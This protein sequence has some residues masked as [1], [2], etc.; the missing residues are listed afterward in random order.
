VIKCEAEKHGERQ[1]KYLTE[2][3]PDNST[4]E[5]VKE[6]YPEELIRAFDII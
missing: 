2:E 4:Y 6:E 5:I 1:H 3:L